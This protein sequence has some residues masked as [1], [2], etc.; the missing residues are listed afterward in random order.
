MSVV[1]CFRASAACV[2]AVGLVALAGCG[3]SGK[4]AYC[5]NRSN[6]ESSIKGL[7]SLD[8]SSGISG[9]KTQLK[10]IQ[11]DAGKL[12]SSA[13]SDF[14]TETSAIKSSVAALDSAVKALP[15][16]P[17]AS[18]LGGVATAAASV[19]SSVKTFMDAS[20]SNCS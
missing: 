3:G 9:L 19:V 13:K 15:P 6:L 7:T 14:P 1:R 4:P 10:T 17:S 11:S 12:V 5:S 8:T 20:K 18:Q 2:A 16:Q